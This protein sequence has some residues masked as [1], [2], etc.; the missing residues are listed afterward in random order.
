MLNTIF[1]WATNFVATYI[2]EIPSAVTTT[3]AGLT[4]RKRKR[5]ICK[6]ERE[7]Q[8]PVTSSSVSLG[9]HLQRGVRFIGSRTGSHSYRTAVD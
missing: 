1:G 8:G 7:R 5:E 9:L 6:A 2:L 4:E 3:Q